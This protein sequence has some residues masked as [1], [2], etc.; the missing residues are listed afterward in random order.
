[1]SSFLLVS[2][3]QNVR[4]REFLDD[5]IGREFQFVLKHKFLLKKHRSSVTSVKNNFLLKNDFFVKKHRIL[6]KT[7]C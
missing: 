4:G 2:G 1:M 6:F 5:C 3:A 7:L